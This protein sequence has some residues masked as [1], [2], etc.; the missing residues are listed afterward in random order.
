MML[1]LDDIVANGQ[2][3]LLTICH[4]RGSPGGERPGCPHLESSATAAYSLQMSYVLLFDIDGTLLTTGGA[5][6]LAMERAL[7]KVFGLTTINGEILAAGR[8]DRAITS[9]LFREHQIVANAEDWSRFQAEYLS[10]LPDTMREQEGQILPGIS[11]LLTKL[12]SLDN[13]SL[14]LLTGN[15]R[16]GAALKL[17]HFDLDHH[18]RFGGFGDDHHDRDDVARVAMAD[19]SHHLGREIDPRRVWVLGDTPADVRC[20]RAI[21][22]NVAAVATGIYSHQELQ[23]TAPDLLFEDFADAAPLLDR[24]CD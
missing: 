8:T 1:F 15:F 11:A 23:P 13:I 22:A 19:A 12:A 3:P 6:Q 18:F 7:A 24:L 5:G 4:T 2:R 21:G 20:A 9:D 14:G 17:Q 10:Q 16:D